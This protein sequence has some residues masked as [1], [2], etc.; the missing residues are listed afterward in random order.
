[1][2][3]L[4]NK[5]DF[6]K[7]NDIYNECFNKEYLVKEKLNNNIYVFEKDKII[8]G[9]FQI[10]YIEDIF[11]NIKYAYINNLCI[12]KEYQNQGYGSILIKEIEKLAIDNK[13]QYIT[14]TSNKERICAHKLYIKNNY[15]IIDTN[16]F[17]KELFY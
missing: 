17:K 5:N 9:M 13:C 14:L 7:I 15:K 2:I 4:I 6:K 12:K 16:I 3:R 10:D 1:M 8:I 11:K